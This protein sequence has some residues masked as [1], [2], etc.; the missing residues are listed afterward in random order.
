MPLFACLGRF[1]IRNLLSAAALAAL[2]AAPLPASAT[3]IAADLNSAAD[4]LLTYDDQNGLE[5]L[6]APLTYGM[7]GNT[8]LATYEGFRWA[9]KS[10]VVGLLTEAGISNIGSNT[11]IAADLAAGNLLKSLI[12]VTASGFGGAVEQ[13]MVKYL[14]DD[15]IYDGLFF[16]ESRNPPAG[17]VGTRTKLDDFGLPVCYGCSQGN[18]SIF[19]VR[20]AEISTIDAPPAAALLAGTALWLRRRRRTP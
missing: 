17:S 1:R 3:L 20:D 14:T 5:W 6:D 12:G 8:A 4:G 16:L 11:S 13:I 18:I 15:L 2:F 7:S 19:L 10:E 9:T